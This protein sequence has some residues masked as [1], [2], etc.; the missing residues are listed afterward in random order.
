MFLEA[1]FAYLRHRF[2]TLPLVYERGPVRPVIVA[3]SGF[4]RDRL[5][6]DFRFPRHDGEAW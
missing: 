4:G 1:V 2:R 3:V 6:Q 5:V